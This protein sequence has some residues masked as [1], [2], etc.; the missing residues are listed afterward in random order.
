MA[1][2]RENGRY[3]RNWKKLLGIYLVVG[4]AVYGLIFLLLRYGGDGSG[5]GLY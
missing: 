4:A 5:G 3:G 1:E 2:N